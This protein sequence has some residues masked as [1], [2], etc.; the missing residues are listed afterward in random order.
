MVREYGAYAPEMPAKMGRI[1]AFEE[2]YAVALDAV[3]RY[4]PNLIVG[5]S[6]G[7]AIL[8]RLTLERHWQGP[9]IFLAQAGVRYGLGDRLPLGIRAILIHGT[10]DTLID[11]SDSEMLAERSGPE[12]VFWPTAGEHR[13]HE[14]TTD[15]TLKKAIER[16]L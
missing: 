2:S 13:L 5:S 12:V 6:F 7:G 14:I 8:M 10:N 16:L 1:N 4:K 3:I 11:A 15:G 9:C